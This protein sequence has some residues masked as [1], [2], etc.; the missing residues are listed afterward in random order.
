MEHLLSKVIDVA[1]SKT[2]RRDSTQGCRDDF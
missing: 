1:V 2:G